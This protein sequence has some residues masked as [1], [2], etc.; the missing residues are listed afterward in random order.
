MN[1]IY[2]KT[3]TDR[4]KYRQNYLANLAVEHSNNTLNLNANQQ[5]KATGQTPTQPTD[6]RTITEKYQDIDRLKVELR[7]GLMGLTDGTNANQIVED[8]TPAE[9]MFATTQFPFIVQDLKPKWKLGIPA[10]IFLAYLR[11]L[12]AKWDQ[13]E[14]VELGLQQATGEAILLGQQQILG[15]MVNQDDLRA[16]QTAIRMVPI[17]IASSASV[18][19][20]LREV[21]E[22]IRDME[23]AIP[24]AQ[25]FAGMDRLPYATRA[26]IQVLLNEALRDFPTRDMLRQ[27]LEELYQ[28]TQ[29]GDERRLEQVLRAIRGDLDI[30]PASRD[31]L[32]RVRQEILEAIAG[33]VRELPAGGGR[34]E[35]IVEAHPVNQEAL[36]PEGRRP[37]PR[38]RPVQGVQVVG[39]RI[40]SV[41]DFN[42]LNLKDK[43]AFLTQTGLSSGIRPPV[44][45]ERFYMTDLRGT[46]N[47]ATGVYWADTNI[48]QLVELWVA[49]KNRIGRVPNK[50]KAD[51]GDFSGEGL[52]LKGRMRGKGL[53]K[54]SSHSIAHKIEAPIVKPKMYA[55]FGSVAINKHKLADGILMLRNPSGG[56][57]ADLPSHRISEK[58]A[59]VFK[60]IVGGS[61]PSFEDIAELADH[62]KDHL[63]KVLHRTKQLDRISVPKPKIR[64][65]NEKELN[66]FEI[67]RGEIMAGNDNK[68]LV[69]EFKVLL[70]KLMNRGL[71]PKRQAHDIL[72]DITSMGL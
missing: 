39:D 14:G 58:L 3:P 12:V 5:Y 47:P 64:S 15:N 40:N 26:D 37:P 28:A 59:K 9:L 60:T 56:A 30:D 72:I 2:A 55:P 22:D 10:P 70:I 16:L 61:N 23:G 33:A 65:E 6:T 50:Y 21:M 31:Q 44:G 46:E 57:L 71:V 35:A 38:E 63:H 34:N 62:D 54:K 49:E 7:S 8:L 24:N 48:P 27:E 69:R 29:M 18:R 51:T 25:D 41:E 52:M 1:P 45:V 66:R 43:K 4:D 42:A 20:L 36:N 17:N 13:T 67:L 32:E 19:N 68:H 11:R 53:V